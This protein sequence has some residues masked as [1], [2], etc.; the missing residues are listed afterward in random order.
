MPLNSLFSW[1]IKKRIHQ[2]DLFKQYPFEVQ[3]DVF[4][5]LIARG[6]KTE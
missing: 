6:S 5:D 4:A 3:G 2:I 1:I